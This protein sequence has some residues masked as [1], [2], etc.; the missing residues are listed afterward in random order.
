MNISGW[1]G[2]MLSGV[3]DGYQTGESTLAS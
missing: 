3:T 1:F 2:F